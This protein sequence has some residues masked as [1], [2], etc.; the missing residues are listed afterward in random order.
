MPYV[1]CDQDQKMF[2]EDVLRQFLRS[3]VVQFP[4][5][6]PQRAEVLSVACGAV[7]VL[8]V[9]RDPAARWGTVFSAGANS[10][11]Q[12]GVGHAAD[13]IDLVR[14]P[15]LEPY[16]YELREVRIHATSLRLLYRKVPELTPALRKCCSFVLFRSLACRSRH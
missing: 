4:A 14:N 6:F 13:P 11:G 12:L 9:A 7:S 2:Y 1:Y 5:P 10:C 3:A 16:R 8:V 15:R